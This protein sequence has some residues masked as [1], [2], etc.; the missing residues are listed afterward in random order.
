MQLGDPDAP[1]SDYVYPGVDITD[2]VRNYKVTLT[3]SFT[4][5][6]IAGELIDEDDLTSRYTIRYI[7]TDKRLRIISSNKRDSTAHIF[8]TNNKE[9]TITFTAKSGYPMYLCVNGVGPRSSSVKAKISA[10]SED[11]FTIVKPLS[12]H[13]Y[14]N[15]EGLD[16]IKA[17]FCGYI[18]LP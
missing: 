9:D 7:D 15:E 16:K 13:E 2:N 10:I 17:P 11:G 1:I 3:C 18:I 12:V 8:L 14:Q 6:D 4:E 5:V